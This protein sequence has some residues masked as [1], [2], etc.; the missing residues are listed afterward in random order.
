MGQVISEV[1]RAGSVTPSKFR[2]PPKRNV[3]GVKV[4][5]TTYEEAL[6][7]VIHAAKKRRS[8]CVSHLAVHGLV[9]G[10]QDQLVKAM[11]DEFEIVAPDGIPVK[12]ALN[13]LYKTQLP[14]RVYGPKFMLRVCER[15]AKERIGI[16]LYGSHRQVVTALSKNLSHRFPKLR[17][18]GCEPSVFRPLTKTEDKLLVHRINDSGASI[19]FLGLGCPLQEQ[20]AYEHKDKIKAVQICVGA[21]FDFHA[22][23]KRMA[24][25]WMQRNGLEWLYRFMQEPARL[26]RRH[27]STYS[28]FIVKLFLQVFRFKILQY[29]KYFD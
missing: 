18:V 8:A 28:I 22:G 9:I 17:I 24:P 13:L 3:L 5:L 15:A 25:K 23:N 4:S 20:F 19:L 21:A 2:W 10:A 27:F 29:R 14:D 6:E 12:I 26:Y 11:L 7:A 1:A 16:Y